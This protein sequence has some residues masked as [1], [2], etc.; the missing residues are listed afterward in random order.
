MITPNAVVGM[1]ESEAA[2][3]QAFENAIDAA[4]SAQNATDPMQKSFTLNAG[5][6]DVTVK[7]R[8]HTFN[9]YRKAKWTVLSTE[10]QYV[11]TAPERKRGGRKPGSKNKPKVVAVVP[12]AP[13][14]PAPVA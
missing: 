9:R 8:E 11:F 12:T 6:Y 4:I 14:A 13:V 10:T 5:D 2:Q 7:V 3:S 1:S